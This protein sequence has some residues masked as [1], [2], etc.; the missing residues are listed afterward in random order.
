MFSSSPFSV[1]RP[2][3]TAVER[4]AGGGN[5]DTI[6]MLS[7]VGQG[8]ADL[9]LA[10]GPRTLKTTIREPG[11]VNRGSSRRPALGSH[12]PVPSLP[13]LTSSASCQ[14]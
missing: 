14:R 13:S 1:A 10:A 6:I 11:H 3:N 12:G 2:N 4:L 7:F 8:L 5:Y 9:P